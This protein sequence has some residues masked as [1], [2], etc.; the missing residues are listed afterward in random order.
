MSEPIRCVLERTGQAVHF[1]DVS[2]GEPF[3][4]E[5]TFWTRTNRY[6]GTDLRRRS[7]SGEEPG[8]SFGSCSFGASEDTMTVEKVTVRVEHA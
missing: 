1:L 4:Y 7:R 2:I 5:G 8:P 6:V 3:F